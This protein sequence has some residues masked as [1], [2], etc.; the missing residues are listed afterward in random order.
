M[1]DDVDTGSE[2]LE[3]DRIKAGL[4]RYATGS[5]SRPTRERAGSPLPTFHNDLDLYDQRHYD[6]QK[7]AM[8][9][10]RLL[11]VMPVGPIPGRRFNFQAD[12]L[13]TPEPAL[14]GE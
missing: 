4:L 6:R 9:L 5:R 1:P 12:P 8:P 13:T 2:A 14:R 3:F 10:H 7:G 11:L